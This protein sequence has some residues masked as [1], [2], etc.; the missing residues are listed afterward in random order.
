MWLALLTSTKLFGYDLFAGVAVLP[1][2]ADS[3][4]MPKLLLAMTLRPAAGST[5]E[6]TLALIDR[7][8]ENGYRIDELLPDRG[9]SYKIPEDWAMEL[10]NRGI[11]QVQDIH[12]AD[13]GIRDQEGIRIVDGVPYCVKKPDALVHNPRP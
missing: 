10:H 2:G 6:P 12:A 1:V 3:D 7:M 9:F 4:E 11:S 5:S 13:H 8:M